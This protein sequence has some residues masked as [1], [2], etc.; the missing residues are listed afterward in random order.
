MDCAAFLSIH[1]PLDAIPFVVCLAV[2]PPTALRASHWPPSR[3]PATASYWGRPPSVRGLLSPIGRSPGGG[4]RSPS[5]G[6]QPVGP[7]DDGRRQSIRWAGLPL[8]VRP[9]PQWALSIGEHVRQS[10]HGRCPLV[11]FE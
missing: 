10:G 2:V 9:L 3:E 11:R 8:P 1:Q 7:I 6:G 4:E 5:I